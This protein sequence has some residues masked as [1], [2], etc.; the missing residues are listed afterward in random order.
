MGGEPHP[1]QNYVSPLPRNY[2]PPWNYVPP[3]T[4]YPPNYV[5]PEL[6][7]PP[8][9][10]TPLNYVHPPELH[11]PRTTYPPELRTPLNYVHPPELHT[12]RTTYPPE[13]RTPLNYV[14]PPELHTPR[15]TY[16]PEL[17]TPP[18]YVPPRNY[19]TPPREADS[20]IRSTSGRY[21]SYWNAF[22]L[23]YHIAKIQLRL[24]HQ[25]V[26]LKICLP[27]CLCF[28]SVLKFNIVVSRITVAEWLARPTAKQEVCSSSLASY[29]C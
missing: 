5:P 24:L 16:P 10:H 28:L 15:T 21:A 20:S 11:T 14:H 2:V 23:F 29:L 8:E 22:L 1:P 19:V 17:R 25:L 12:P 3:Q 18:N 7:T 9:L 4:T 26:I 6:R 13:L 27:L